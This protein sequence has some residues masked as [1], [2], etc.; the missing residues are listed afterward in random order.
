M[1]QSLLIFIL[2][3]IN[4]EVCLAEPVLMPNWPHDYFTPEDD[5]FF[6]GP[7][8]GLTYINSSDNNQTYLP[9]GLYDSVL[10]MLDYEANISPDWPRNFPGHVCHGKP[11]V[12]DVDQDGPEELIF[13]VERWEHSN[14]HRAIH[15]MDIWGNESP[16]FPVVIPNLSAFDYRCTPVLIDLNEDTVPEMVYASHLDT[17][18]YIYSMDGERYYDFQGSITPD[19][20]I[21]FHFAVGDLDRDNYNDLIV[22]AGHCIFAFDRYGNTLS[23]WPI[24]FREGQYLVYPYGAPVL[25][26][27]D[28]DGYLEVIITTYRFN[29][30]LETGWLEIYN[31]DGS[32]VEGWPFYWSDGM[33][34][35]APVVGDLNRD[36]T[37]EIVVTGTDW[38]GPEY[39]GKM[40]IFEPDGSIF[41]GFPIEIESNNW[42]DPIIADL[43]G[44]DF[45]DILISSV[46]G[47]NQNDSGYSRYWAYNRNGEVLEGWP[48]EVRGNGGL[49]APII[50]DFDGNGTANIALVSTG[51]HRSQYPH[52]GSHAW[53]YMY[54]LGIPYDSS[55]IEWGQ[56]GH[57]RWNTSNYEFREPP[58]TAI[59][60]DNSNLPA[61]IT[62]TNHPNP[63][64]SATIIE[65]TIEEKG[66]VQLEIYNLLGQKV[67][68]LV[69]DEILPGKHSVRWNADRFSS[70]IYFSVLKTGDVKH[71]RRMVLLK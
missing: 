63:F 25:A 39:P 62:L 32:M 42:H 20:F 19:T 6:L 11:L 24:R 26:D 7:Y 67:A 23:G 43:D 35:C 27:I 31:H 16:G 17:T 2:L 58:R 59:A 15:A 46:N 56:A 5:N 53:I 50:F 61:A 49:A 13:T 36:G 1:K 64:N 69:D 22:G 3:I 47:Y 71:S 60:E 70:G 34:W 48:I 10:F 28:N 38:S 65:Y 44:D 18:F 41:P 51:P 8:V 66:K 21:E 30:P 54:E 52:L 55:T 12:Y 14:Y 29:G 4:I 37:L 68:T 33:P 45:P 57:D 9:V 40:W